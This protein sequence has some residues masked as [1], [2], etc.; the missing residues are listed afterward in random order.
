MINVIGSFG[1]LLG[2]IAYG[3]HLVSAFRSQIVGASSIRGW[4]I[5]SV[6][7]VLWATYGF[8]T[9]TAVQAFGFSFA[10]IV[11]VTL[12]VQIWRIRRREESMEN[13]RHL[14]A[15]NEAIAS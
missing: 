1:F 12:A 8:V 15:S 6:G 7:C 3:P 14:I 13:S 11:E 2:W 4:L 10:A 5:S 9:H